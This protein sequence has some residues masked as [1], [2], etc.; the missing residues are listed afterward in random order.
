MFG[1]VPYSL[2]LG[3]IVKLASDSQEMEVVNIVKRVFT[4]DEIGV[5][6]FKDDGSYQ[7]MNGFNPVSLHK[8][9]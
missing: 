2:K 6:Y 7:I 8:V 1:K 4:H 3:D 9:K 5:L